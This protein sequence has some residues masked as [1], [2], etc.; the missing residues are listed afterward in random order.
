MA[1]DKFAEVASLRDDCTGFT[2]KMDEFRKLVE[3]AVTSVE[4]QVQLIERENLKAIGIRNQAEGVIEIRK[5]KE[6]ELRAVIHERQVELERLTAE[7]ESM[8]KL[9]QE[10]RVLIERLS[11]SEPQGS[12]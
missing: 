12:H 9:G 8:V 11:N 7:Y 3:T 2:E 1:P 10:Q 6:E 4:H 5:R